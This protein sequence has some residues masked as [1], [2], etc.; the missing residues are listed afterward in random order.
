[1]A[2]AVGLSLAASAAQAED[3]IK[4]GVFATLEGALTTLRED[5]IRGMEVAMKQA[6]AKAV[7]HPR[8]A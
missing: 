5:A 7:S 1:M 8:R 4:I 2:A 3:K 6:G